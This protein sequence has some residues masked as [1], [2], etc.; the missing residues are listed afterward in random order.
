MRAL[1]S[2]L[3]RPFEPLSFLFSSR[4]ILNCGAEHSETAETA[5]AQ[6][7]F[8]TSQQRPPHR[9][10]DHCRQP[11]ALRGEAVRERLAQYRLREADGLVFRWLGA[12]GDYGFGNGAA[13]RYWYADAE[14]MHVGD[15]PPL[16]ASHAAL[17]A[18]LYDEVAL[19][20]GGR[21]WREPAPALFGD[22]L[23]HVGRNDGTWGADATADLWELLGFGGGGLDSDEGMDEFIAADDE[24]DGE[25]EGEEESESEAAAEGEGEGEEA[26]SEAE[27][28]KQMFNFF[29]GAQ[30]GAPGSTRAARRAGPYEHDPDPV[31]DYSE[32]GEESDEFIVHGGREGEEGSSEEVEH[33]FT[34]DALDLAEREMKKRRRDRRRSAGSGSDQRRPPRRKRAVVLAGDASDDQQSGGEGGGGVRARV[35]A[36]TESRRR[37]ARGTPPRRCV[38]DDDDSD[39]DDE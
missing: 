4:R 14:D 11:A 32:Y 1:A 23:G 9:R 28:V 34:P 36:E 39:D 16:A 37:T 31:A 22:E 29:R 33:D 27:E 12:S 5:A 17:Y 8:R 25:E 19:I 18:A 24:S 20:T 30:D 13:Q 3:D 15:A 21:G 38:I 6:M 26:D 35:A 7:C 10:A 2:A